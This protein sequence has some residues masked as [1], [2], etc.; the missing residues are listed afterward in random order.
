MHVSREDVLVVGFGVHIALFIAGNHLLCC[1]CSLPSSST[2]AVAGG[3]LA[4]VSVLY[5]LPMLSGMLLLTVDI[6]SM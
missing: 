2:V 1:I 3:L 6:S 4:D 5:Y